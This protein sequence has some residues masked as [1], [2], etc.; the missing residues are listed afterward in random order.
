MKHAVSGVMQRFR[1]MLAIGDAGEQSDVVLLQRFSTK[2]DPAAFEVIVRRHGPMVLGV[3]RR[4]L[5]DPAD[6]DDAFQ[7]TFAILMRKAS[8]LSHPEL[9]AGWLF[10]V[11]FRTARKARSI[12]LRRRSRQMPL[13]DVPVEASIADVMWRELQ[14]IFDEEVNRLPEKLRLP[15]VMCF[16]E[17]RTKRSAAQMLGW[18]EGTFA[19]RLQQ[20]RE[21]LRIR[22]ERRGIALSASGLSLALFQGTASA[23]VPAVLVSSTVQSA[24]LIAAGTVITSPVALLTQGVIHSMFLSK[25]KIVAALV[26]TAGVIGGGTG[27][28]LNSGTP[29]SDFAFAAQPGFTLTQNNGGQ[30]TFKVLDPNAT[31][32]ATDELLVLQ[33]ELELAGVK[34]DQLRLEQQINERIVAEWKKKGDKSLDEKIKAKI[35][36]QLRILMLREQIEAQIAELKAKAEQLKAKR[37]AE[38]KKLLDEKRLLEELDKDVRRINELSKS[39][40]GKKLP[41][42]KRLLEA[43]E[44]EAQIQR[45]ENERL[46]RLLE[47]LK[48][49][50]EALRLSEME[51]RRQAEDHR[52]QI[53]AEKTHALQLEKLAREEERQ[54]RSALEEARRRAKANSEQTHDDQAA[55]Q[56]RR[57]EY[58]AAAVKLKLQEETLA[59]LKAN[60]DAVP[61][62]TLLKAEAE[63]KLAKLEME[64]ALYSLQMTEAKL[65]VSGKRAPEPK[66][67][68]DKPVKMV[69]MDIKEKLTGSLKLGAGVNSDAGTSGSIVVNERNFDIEKTTAE[70]EEA[71]ATLKLKELQLQRTK[72][73]VE[74][75]FAAQSAVDEAAAEF[76]KAQ[77]QLQVARVNL[78]ILQ[79]K[80]QTQPKA[81][82]K[83][84]TSQQPYADGQQPLS[85][86]MNPK[87]KKLL[88]DLETKYQQLLKLKDAGAVSESTVAETRIALAEVRIKIELQTVIEEREREVRRAKQLFEAGVITQADY[89]KT[90]EALKAATKRWTE[91]LP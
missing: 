72:Q 34:K 61:E 26:L 22:L 67:N 52:R 33:K 35:E 75:G 90:V 64:R 32:E 88:T 13:L 59:K 40:E 58:K 18:P 76:N 23:T 79:Q 10:Q 2:A 1:Q 3:C 15:V 39:A 87:T 83:P 74:K 82:Q 36:E 44:K 28:V 91:P 84:G 57:A 14:P 49:E 73:L 85:T 37:L 5:R 80:R 48:A 54:A 16:L 60:R 25:L 29:G 47:K 55:E 38:K 31:F 62:I 45:K 12:R 46:K 77:A 42:E 30:G 24:A 11:A 78:A 86:G 20:A 68:V 70:A 6:A 27:W 41:D 56:Q 69:P 9:L 89:T 65:A 21:L 43:Q 81:D 17:G 51:S 4:L 66:A 53:E 50:N 63:L 7:A 19:C 8:T 71:E